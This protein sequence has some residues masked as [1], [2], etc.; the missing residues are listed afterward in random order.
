MVPSLNLTRC[1]TLSSS[2]MIRVNP[3]SY[4][5][6]PV[7]TRADDFWKA[8]VDVGS[9]RHLIFATAFML[10]V[11][12]RA[13]T[14]FVVVD[15]TFK[16]VKAPFYQLWSVHAFDCSGGEVKQV[17]LL[18]VLM[19][20]KS[21]TV[22]IAVS[23]R[24]YWICYLGHRQWRRLCVILRQRCRLQCERYFLGCICKAV[25]FTGHKVYGRKYRTHSYSRLI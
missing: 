6:V 19:S 14:R 24:L 13:K 23:Y 3:R 18:F 7:T 10:T 8:D 4:F 25:P 11:L 22:T 16:L 20:G 15:G 21:D 9:R 2:R 17:P 1:G 12:A 5:C